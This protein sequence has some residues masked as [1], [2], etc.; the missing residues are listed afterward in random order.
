[1]IA[2]QLSYSGKAD[3]TFE[4]ETPPHPCSLKLTRA[5]TLNKTIGDSEN[6][7]TLGDLSIKTG[8]LLTVCTKGFNSV[9]KYPLLNDEKTDLNARA[10]DIFSQIFNSYAVSDPEKPKEGLYMRN[11]EVTNFVKG[12]T[13]ENCE[14]NDHRVQTILSFSSKKDGKLTR[15][16]F[17]NFYRNSC[18]EK[19]AL[20][21]VRNN[22]RNHN[23]RQDLQQ[24]PKPG[25]DDN[26]LQIRP[27]I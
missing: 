15:E 1:M 17:L 3:G 25:Q 7:T 23:F 27:T 4:L 22:L 8:E 19:G 2:W 14:I 26:I 13:N 5:T 16:D 24:D 9:S 20:A 18:I 12:S 10:I 21:T 11:T 6:G